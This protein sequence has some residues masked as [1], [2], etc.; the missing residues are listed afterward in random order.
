MQPSEIRLLQGK[1]MLRLSWP[2][3]TAELE[4]EYLRVESP[5]AEV[6]GHGEGQ[7]R[8][9]SG[10]QGVSITGLEAVGAYAVKIVFSDGHASGL[11]TWAYLRTLAEEQERR[12]SAYLEDLA[13][14]GLS[15]ETARPHGVARKFAL[16]C[17]NK[18]DPDHDGFGQCPD[19][20][21]RDGGCPPPSRCA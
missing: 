21:R 14:A 20:C 9:V 8:L 12:W 4:A 17:D 3:R 1:T 13:R 11:F 10:K 7:A 6:K 19:G 5:S 18:E 16:G 15:R 2:D